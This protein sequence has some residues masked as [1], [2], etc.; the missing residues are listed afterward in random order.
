MTVYRV[1]SRVAYRSHLPGETFEAT[2][3]PAAERR[4]LERG[5]IAVVERSTPRIRKGSYTLPKP[6]AADAAKEDGSD[7]PES[8]NQGVGPDGP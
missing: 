3:E 7:D 4:A 8:A 6:A 2:L 5:A 1:T